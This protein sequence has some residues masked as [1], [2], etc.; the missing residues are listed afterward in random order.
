MQPD[1][2]G[3]DFKRTVGAATAVA[4]F[5]EDGEDGKLEAK[6]AIIFACCF[7]DLSLSA[8][9]SPCGVG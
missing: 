3:S 2:S 1:D 8:S 5:G 7:T 6:V 4:E 9:L